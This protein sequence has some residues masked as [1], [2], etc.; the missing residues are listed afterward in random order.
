MDIRDI[1]QQYHK[2]TLEVR[3]AYADCNCPETK[4]GYRR[5]MA[6]RNL[7]FKADQPV[8]ASVARQ[9]MEMAVPGGYNGFEAKLLSHISGDVIL[10]R[11]GSV[12]LYLCPDAIMEGDLHENE[13]DKQEDGTTR[14]WWD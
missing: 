10:A 6:K 7:H 3:D 14:L 2:V 4:V 12:C 1:P 5:G 13:N 11:E 9:I 8:P